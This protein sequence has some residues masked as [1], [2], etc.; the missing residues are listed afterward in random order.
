MEREYAKSVYIALPVASRDLVANTVATELQ[1]PKQTSHSDYTDVSGTEVDSFV[2]GRGKEVEQ[3]TNLFDSNIRISDSSVISADSAITMFDLAKK[4]LVKP[5]V[6]SFVYAPSEQLREA[7]QHSN[8]N[9]AGFSFRGT[10]LR[11]RLEG[12]EE[13][14]LAFNFSD[15]KRQN[16]EFSRVALRM[17]DEFDF[18]MLTFTAIRRR[19]NQIQEFTLEW[20]GKMTVESS[21][22]ISSA[23]ALASYSTISTVFGI[24]PLP[25]SDSTLQE[26]GFSSDLR[27]LFTTFNPMANAA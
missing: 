22:P 15:G 3:V 11:D 9:Y 4:G 2:V 8:R 27:N 1:E 14:Y 12:H 20:S 6:L 13:S 19:S 10:I 24:E 18:S 17:I 23:D 26:K 7:M 5:A 16:P 21:S 25:Y